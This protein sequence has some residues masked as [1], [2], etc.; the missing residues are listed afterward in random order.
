[1]GDRVFVHMPGVKR[2]K[3]H[4]FARSFDG[5]YRILHIDETGAEVILV[6]QLEGKKMR[7]ALNRLRKCPREVGREDEE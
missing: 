4:K 5:P 7:I 2:G 3:A 1:M 6:G